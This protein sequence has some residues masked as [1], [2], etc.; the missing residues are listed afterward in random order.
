MQ[1]NTHKP[2]GCSLLFLPLGAA[3]HSAM[4]ERLGEPASLVTGGPAWAGRVSSLCGLSCSKV[5]TPPSPLQLSALVG[6]EELRTRYA[7]LEQPAP[8]RES[9]D[10]QYCLRMTLLLP[11][12]SAAHLSCVQSKQRASLRMLSWQ[13][14]STVYEGWANPISLWPCS[15]PY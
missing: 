3:T 15:T 13:W 1:V 11:N 8:R 9:G 10:G 7:E 5:P 6:S 2:A 12:P 4:V 14:A